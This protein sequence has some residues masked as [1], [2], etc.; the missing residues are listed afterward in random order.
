LRSALVLTVFALLAFV[1]SA[2]GLLD[3][4]EG[5]TTRLKLDRGISARLK[6]EGVRV[7]RVKPARLSGRVATM[8]VT[9]GQIDPA[10]ASGTLTQD[11]G[12]GFVV[13]KRTVPVDHFGIN[14][15]EEWVSA[16][17]AGKRVRFASF[18]GF[19][20]SRKGFGNTWEVGSLPLTGTAAGL[21]NRRLGLQGVFR[22]GRSFGSIAGT[23]VP[24]ST[25][26]ESGSILL[27]GIGNFPFFGKLKEIGADLRGFE[28]TPEKIEPPTWRFPLITGE[29]GLDMRSGFVGAEAGWRIYA[30]PEAPGAVMTLT[31]MS[32]YFEP[33]GVRPLTERGR[34]VAGMQIHDASG[35]PKDLGTVTLGTFG[36]APGTQLVDPSARTMTLLGTPVTITPF[37]ADRLNEIFSG[38]KGKPNLFEYGEPIGGMEVALKSH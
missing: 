29:M 14:T 16:R 10:G 4:I 15:A 1:P 8:P 24:E 12:I 23:T 11:G 18:E 3:V 36:V 13:G 32:V 27:V 2:S 20:F 28:V 19:D 21:L 31:N 17:I 30:N 25:R 26:V 33:P 35:Q 6:E 34:L 9:A 5:G 22:A 37:F 38:P 7:V